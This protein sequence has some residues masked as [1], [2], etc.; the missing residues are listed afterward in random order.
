MKNCPA[1]EGFN[2]KGNKLERPEELGNLRGL[3]V[4]LLF[5]EGNPFCSTTPMP[6]LFSKLKGI[7]PSLLQVDA[8]TDMNLFPPF[9]YLRC[10]P[11]RPFGGFFESAE[12]ESVASGVVS[13][14]ITPWKLTEAELGAIYTENSYFSISVSSRAPKSLPAIP[15]SVVRNIASR[16]EVEEVAVGPH[17]IFI[18]LKKLPELTIKDP[19]C[20]DCVAF[21]ANDT[22]MVINLYG[23]VFVSGTAAIFSRSI[24]I[25]PVPRVGNKVFSDMICF[26]DIKSELFFAKVPRFGVWWWVAGKIVVDK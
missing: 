21:S 22:F 23:N 24:V 1:I 11:P 13:A 16:G 18:M 6:D 9:Q 14:I 4:R 26:H 12:C 7:F 25:V 20:A 3:K 19:L 2:F 10:F 5:L 15:T 8:Y 17:D